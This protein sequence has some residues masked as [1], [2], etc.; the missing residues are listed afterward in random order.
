MQ[1]TV[2]QMKTIPVREEKLNWCVF[3]VGD[4]EC[5]IFYGRSKCL[6]NCTCI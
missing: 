4:D 1:L 6:Y 2:C 3:E 5:A